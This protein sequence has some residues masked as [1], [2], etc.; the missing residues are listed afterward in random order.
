MSFR[1]KYFVIFALPVS[2]TLAA[3]G[4]TELSGLFG[5]A[6][7]DAGGQLDASAVLDTSTPDSDV[8]P[9]PDASA[10]ETSIDIDT[11]IP[12]PPDSGR[13]TGV[14]DAGRD[15]PKVITDTMGTLCGAVGGTPNYCDTTSGFCCASRPQ[16]SNVI[17]SYACKP[18]GAQCNGNSQATLDCDGP[19]DCA[20]VGEVCCGEFITNSNIATRV[21]TWDSS[22]CRTKQNCAGLRQF[23]GEV[24]QRSVFCNLAAGNADCP[25]GTCTASMLI[26]GYA[27]CVTP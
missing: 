17:D 25:F 8:P 20:A 15:A 21:N 5:N 18:A 11:G 2:A 10:P 7:A 19:E 9:L 12:N 16:N 27:R 23:N 24:Y 13:D 6:D 14:A 3:C 4:G 1:L 22:V 26:S